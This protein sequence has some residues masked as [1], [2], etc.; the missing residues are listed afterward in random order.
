[1]LLRERI[2]ATRT[3]LVTSSTDLATARSARTNAQTRVTAAIRKKND[4]NRELRTLNGQ[5]TI[6][7]SN[8]S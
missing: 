5:M 3:L 6:L 1:M 8:N 4:K 2:T 7:K